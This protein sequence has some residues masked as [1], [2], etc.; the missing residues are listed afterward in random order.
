[1]NPHF[2]NSIPISKS[3]ALLFRLPILD[4]L[5]PQIQQ[6]TVSMTGLFWR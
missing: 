3:V 2:A 5:R 1:M 6:P 4:S